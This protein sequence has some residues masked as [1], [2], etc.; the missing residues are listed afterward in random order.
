M[1]RIRQRHTDSDIADLLDGCLV[2]FRLF[3][4][5]W[6]SLPPSSYPLRWIPTKLLSLHARFV[7]SSR[8]AG[9][10][11]RFHST[12]LAF[13]RESFIESSS[14]A[15]GNKRNERIFQTRRKMWYLRETIYYY[16]IEEI[17]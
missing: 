11:K 2:N 17:F 3:F 9:N 5:N 6:T 16:R 4:V 12:P 8:V 14:M 15:G 7:R 10:L 13:A 1:T